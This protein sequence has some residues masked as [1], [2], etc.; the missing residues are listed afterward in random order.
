MAAS[1]FQVSGTFGPVWDVTGNVAV[2]KFH[3]TIGYSNGFG[4]KVPYKKM[5]LE[6]NNKV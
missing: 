3:L 4:G 5:P 1:L 6:A 2:Y